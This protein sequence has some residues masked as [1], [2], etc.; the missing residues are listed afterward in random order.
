MK[1]KTFYG[2]MSVVF[3]G[4]ALIVLLASCGPPADPPMPEPDFYDRDGAPCW[5][6]TD[7]IWC[8]GEEDDAVPGYLYD[9]EDGEAVPIS[10]P[11]QY[12]THTWYKV[13]EDT[14]DN[15]KETCWWSCYG[16]SAH[17]AVTSGYG[18]C[19]QPY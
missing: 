12:H 4:L 9:L 5:V 15:G 7:V 13:S 14:D 10:G 17:T 8:E 2:T 3:F 1:A 11:E 19:S 6:Y 16:D 18:F